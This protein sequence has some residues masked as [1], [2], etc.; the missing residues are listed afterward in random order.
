MYPCVVCKG[1]RCK[2]YFGVE[3]CPL[4]AK[5]NL[6][7]RV[8]PKSEFI[9]PIRVPFVGRYGYPNVR[10]GIITGSD[11]HV[12]RFDDEVERRMSTLS[13]KR[14][15]NIRTPEQTFQ[16]IS[17]ADRA[18]DM[19]VKIEKA[20]ID[21]TFEP[22]TAPSGGSAELKDLRE[23]E[24]LRE[25]QLAGR[26]SGDRD[27]R[28]TDA[29][30]ELS[31][32]FGEERISQ[33][34]STGA[35]GTGD[36]RKQVPTRWS[37]TAADSALSDDD[38]AALARETI[39]GFELYIGEH[40]GNVF[41]VAL[42]PGPYAYELIEL[43]V[44]SGDTMTDFETARGRKEYAQ[45]TAGGYYAARRSISEHLRD[46]DREAQ[47]IALRL[48]TDAYAVPLGVWVV[49]EAVRDAMRSR[50]IR[51]DSEARMFAFVTMHAKKHHGAQVLGVLSRSALREYRKVQPTL[52]SF[53]R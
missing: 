35:I 28:A 3:F 48:I 4:K 18:Y 42:M 47:A 37:I 6:R 7:S 39:E 43:H 34:L 46:R 25:D 16:A 33:I 12:E 19:D 8:K 26:I 45:E 52:D 22:G 14:D 23:S 20:R 13:I 53:K 31:S 15:S 5:L 32:R 29:M 40:F 44:S 36:R 24:H 30:V 11:E 10:S 21:P 41:Y 2:E 27:L 38:R 50:V 9:E 17:L 1:R 49:R 51:F